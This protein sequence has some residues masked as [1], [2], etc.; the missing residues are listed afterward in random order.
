M[1]VSGKNYILGQFPPRFETAEQLATQFAT[2]EAYGLDASYVNDYGDAVAGAA[3]ESIRSV[4]NDVYPEP[5]NLVFAIIGD[6]NLIREQVARYGEVTEMS[7][8]DPRFH[9]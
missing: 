8:T 5:D 7:I 3:G 1:V 4:I 6:A 9:P 2:L